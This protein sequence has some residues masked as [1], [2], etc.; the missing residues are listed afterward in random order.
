[1]DRVNPSREDTIAAI[2]TAEGNGSIAVIRVS[3]DKTRQIIRDIFRA[4][5]SKDM[6]TELESHRLY[7]GRIVKPE[8][9]DLI[10]EVL[11]VY[12]ES[13]RSY[14]GED[15][16]E[17]HSHGGYLAPRNVLEVIYKLGARPANPG[18]FSLRAFLNGKMDLAQ[19]EAVA[20][21]V[22]AQTKEGLKQAE[23]QLEGA[24]SEKIG[25]CKETV[26]DVLAEVEAQVDFP[27]EDI[28]PIAKESME[29]RATGL[30][31]E[32]KLLIGTYDEGRII[33]YGVRAAILGKPNVGKSSLLN[34]LL[35]KDRAIISPRP[36]TT[37]DF[38]QESINIRGIPLELTDTAGI[39]STKDEIEQ[40]G[41]ELAKKKVR[42]AEL[43]IIVIDGSSELSD[44]DYEVLSEIKG[45][46]AVVVLNK[47]DVSSRVKIEML[48]DYM[49][50][51]LIIS[52]SARY[53]AGIEELK[54][55]IEKVLLNRD[56]APQG[57][58]IVLTE[59]RHKLSLDKALQNLLSF[60]EILRIDE[61]PEFLALNLRSTLD[62]LGEITGEVTTEDV[63]GRIFSKFCVGK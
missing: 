5:G 59:L 11:C 37:R 7:Y 8:S 10:D 23:L 55:G 17:I 36:G 35:N 28:E 31:E 52:T 61:S 2:A 51:D 56:C 24:L 1:M 63:L 14:T 45:R 26:L 15:V 60:I 39:R 6:I 40:A 38:I 21:I 13:P 16:V 9:L 25:G 12:M 48:T 20:D 62:S 41:V 49:S 50:R 44:D 3:G 42:Q 57:N 46:R 30:I 27:E 47:S 29:L 18:E 19:A 43:L 32:I 54:D 33:K 53:G 58:E 4:S 34:C 22:N